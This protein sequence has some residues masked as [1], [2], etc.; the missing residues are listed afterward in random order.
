M[1]GKIINGQIVDCDDKGGNLHT[2]ELSILGYT[3]PE[4]CPIQNEI[5]G[6]VFTQK[7]GRVDLGSLNWEYDNGYDGYLATSYPQ[8]K[9]LGWTVIFKAMSTFYTIKHMNTRTDKCIC[10]YT[11][12]QLYLKDSSY[13]TAVSLKQSL[14]G[15][16]IYYELATPITHSIADNNDMLAKAN[17]DTTVNL[18]NPTSQTTTVNGVTFTN[19]GDGTFTLNGTATNTHYFR[20]CTVFIP[21]SELIILGSNTNDAGVFI[22]GKTST[23][24]SIPI[25]VLDV[26][27]GKTRN[28]GIK[29]NKDITY[30]NLLIKPMLTTNLSA[31]YEDFVSYTGSTGSLNGDVAEIASVLSFGGAGLHSSIFRGKYLGNSFTDKQKEAI[32]NGTFDDMWVG[33]YWIINGVTWRIAHPDYWLNCGD[34]ACT[35]HHL[36]IVPDTTLYSAKM[37]STNTTTGAY[38]GSEMYKTNLAQA[39]TIINNAFGSAN[40]LNHRE[41]LANAT[42]ATSDPTYETAGGWYDST[43]ELMTEAMVYGYEPFHNVEVNGAIPTNYTIDKSQLALFRL[44]HSKIC[45]RV[46]WWLRDVV[47]STYFAFVADVGI[48]ANHNASNSLG[49]R[50]VFAIKG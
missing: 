34:T 30:N 6:N 50:P 41:Y 13:T 10:S 9:H 46:N 31:Q 16:Y 44:D 47:S 38:V 23:S 3:V 21:N 45:N 4:E 26:D 14:Q 11:L 48:C 39:K 40:I 22:E 49:V 28:A 12:T 17:K 42:K 1:I 29:I 2:I 37:N 33:D 35:D 43:V 15:K 7:V 27:K 19:N 8:H 5:D 18:L 32:R 20:I 36:L 24:G 25:K